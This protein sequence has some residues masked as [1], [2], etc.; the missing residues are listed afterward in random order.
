MYISVL[1][2]GLKLECANKS[3]NGV[4]VRVKDD[5]NTHN[6]LTSHVT[7]TVTARGTER[8]SRGHPLKIFHLTSTF[9]PIALQ[10]QNTSRIL[11]KLVGPAILS[12]SAVED[13][14]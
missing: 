7:C 11:F 12:L 5:P 10:C 6:G 4:Q 9:H 3:E 14:H 2:K 1:Y 13:T 8:S